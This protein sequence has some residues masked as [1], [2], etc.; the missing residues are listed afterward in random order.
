MTAR[1]RIV[2]PARLR[3]MRVLAGGKLAGISH[4]CGYITN[5]HAFVSLASVDNKHAETGTEVTVLWGEK[6]NSTKPAV[7][8]HV[9]VEIRAVVAPAPYVDFARREYRSN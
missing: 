1:R 6:P 2:D 3:D 9:Q 5:E 7:E 8:P 4:D